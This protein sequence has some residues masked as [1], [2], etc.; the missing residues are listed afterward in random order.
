MC[1]ADVGDARIALHKNPVGI[2]EKSIPPSVPNGLA[3]A[4]SPADLGDRGLALQP[5]NYK[6]KSLL[7]GESSPLHHRCLQRIKNCSILR[8]HRQLDP[9]RF[10]SLLEKHFIVSSFQFE[11]DHDSG[12]NPDPRKPGNTLWIR[13]ARESQIGDR[14][15]RVLK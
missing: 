7:P 11:E 4:F 3:D 12:D 15:E 10:V 14:R 9:A 6:F 1:V 8:T 13:E 5:F 2:C